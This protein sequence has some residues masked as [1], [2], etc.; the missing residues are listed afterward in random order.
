MKTLLLL[1][2]VFSTPAFA[3]YNCELIVA[4]PGL[5][6]GEGKWPF[7]VSDTGK[8]HGGNAMPFNAKEH[9]LEVEVNGNWMQVKWYRSGKKTAE[10]IFV[11][12]KEDRARARSMLL[13]DP[14]AE[15]EQVSLACVLE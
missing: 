6:G 10:G 2:T 8:S 5:T 3:A 14:A 15:R 11:L 4:A 12:G 13:I 1:L 7:R 9:S